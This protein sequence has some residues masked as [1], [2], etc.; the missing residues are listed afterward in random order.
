MPFDAATMPILR[1]PALYLA[2]ALAGAV[3]GC[4]D[5]PGSAPGS[6]PAAAP[7]SPLENDAGAQSPA[8]EHG[9]AAYVFTNRVRTP[10]SRTNFL[11]LLPSLDAQEV[12]LERALPVPGVSRVRVHEGKVFVFEGE[13]ATVVRYGVSEE[14]ELEEE[15]RF[16]MAGAGVAR[17]LTSI[18]FISAERAYYL[19]TDL[20]QVVV[21]NPSAME[22]VSTFD[23]PG[24][25]REGFPL[26]S[27]GRPAVVADQVAVSVSFSNFDQTDAVLKVIVVALSATRDEVIAVAEDDRC[28]L[29]GSGFAYDGAYYATGEWVS[30]AYELVIGT[31]APSCM[32]RYDPQ[33]EAF[34]MDY[35]VDLPAA[36]G[37]P[38]FSGFFGPQDGTLAFRAYDAAQSVSE[39][40]GTLSGA[41][42]Y[43]GL[44]LWRWGLFDVDTQTAALV[45]GL[46]LT[47]QSFAPS[48]I[49]GKFY[50]PVIDEETQTSQLFAIYP[51]GNVT[52][53]VSATGD[54]IYTARVR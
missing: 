17:F 53:S 24:F 5:A 29:G 40:A 2:L 4:D 6:A 18:L 34:D 37:V 35:Y 23:V 50:V 30:G 8:E 51:D 9:T 12:N 48:T 32:L 52:P 14:L 15:A 38:H 44:E 42:E 19:D 13:T 43:F 25:Q 11:S 10:D 3:A 20:G 16:S 33:T 27:I 47:G 1:N 45:D 7:D 31:H 21:F 26:V 36:T 54:I 28:A 39:L 46:P 49:D 22:L 41:P